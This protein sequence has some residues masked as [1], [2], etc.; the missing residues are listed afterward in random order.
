MVEGKPVN[1]SATF[2]EAWYE[3]AQRGRF[4]VVEAMGAR[5]CGLH[6]NTAVK[7][8]LE[9]SYIDREPERYGGYDICNVPEL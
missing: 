6:P 3:I 7:V 8:T 5:L 1:L 9:C 4:S 2:H